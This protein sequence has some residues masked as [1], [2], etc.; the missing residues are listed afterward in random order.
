MKKSLIGVVVFLILAGTGGYFYYNNTVLATGDG[1]E[2]EPEVQ[3]SVVRR[4]DITISATGAG[5][6][7]PA[8]EV[9]LSFSTG[10]VL[11]ELLVQ[12]G[13]EVQAG[14]ML[15]QLD[16]TNALQ[17]VANAELQLAQ[18]ALQTE[19]E[20]V[21]RAIALAQISV[22]Q[23]A[24]N[25]ASAQADLDELLNWTA[26]ETEVI[27]AQANLESAQASHED[28]LRQDASAGNSL[29]A[30]RISLDQAE[31][32]L[33]SAQGVY[34]EAFDPE[35][36][37]ELADPR[38]YPRITAE[39][40]RAADSLLRAQEAHQIA[41]ANFYPAAGNLNNSTA[42]NTQSSVI[43]AEISL[44]NALASPTE[45]EIEAARINIEQAALSLQQA[46]LNLE[47]AEDNAQAEISQTQAQLNLEAAQKTLAETVLLAPMAGTVTAVTA[48]PGESVSAGFIT[49]ADLRRPLVEVFLDE[50]DLDKVAD[51][52]D[53]EVFF[54]AMP[55][56]VFTGQVIQV[57]P[58]LSVVN[59][60]TA[61]RTVVQLTADTLTSSRPL[62]IGLNATVDVIGGRT[63]GALLVPIEAL[64][65]LSADSYAVFVMEDG[66]P[67]LRLV[68]VGLKDFTFAEIL[69]GVEQG[70]I[71]TTGIIETQ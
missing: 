30:S 52:F 24:I 46:V 6:V 4:G 70:E 67:K 69:S 58:Q 42:L 48:Q 49:L 8:E 12:V 71:V 37:W 43:N 34:D 1:N 2:E 5:S 53:V 15:A 61:V 29:T 57:D 63:Q 21:E 39:R 65:E 59:G 56:D 45:M 47:A 62:P 41:Q 26:D 14:D 68:E 38:L 44:E 23:A 66:E 36:E 27:L 11:A 31:R 7:I 17:A 64:R 19:T 3:T 40:E 54:D 55:D 16:D 9:A 60:V 35:R 25:L 22:D 32:D 51:G 10:G 20:A 50:T 28:A 13:D 18:A 33:A